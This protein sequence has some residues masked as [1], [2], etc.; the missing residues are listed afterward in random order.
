MT[1][2]STPPPGAAPRTR[3]PRRS[4]SR[5]FLLSLVL[6]LLVLELVVRLGGLVDVNAG[7]S[8]PQQAAFNAAG[9]FVATGDRDLPYMNRPDAATNVEGVLYRHDAQGRRIAEEDDAALTP[10][11]RVVVFLGDST[12]YGLGLRFQDT[13]PDLTA[14]LLNTM[15]PSRTIAARNHGVCG[16]GIEQELALYERLADALP[17]DA[18][19]VL[20]VF[21]NDF[22]GGRFL[23][24]DG[25]KL[26]YAD[27]LP[28]PFALK[29]WLW[30]SA[31]YRGL[32]SSATARRQAQGAFDASNPAN[33]GAAL[34]NVAALAARVQ[35]DGRRLLVA[36]LPAMERL[37][38]YLFSEPVGKLEQ[39][40]EDMGATFVDLLQ[41]FLDERERQVAEYEARTGETPGIGLRT[42]FLSQFWI[43]DPA[44]HH[45]NAT[46]NGLA[47]GALA[48]ALLP[49]L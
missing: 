24:D 31:L 38:P 45:L 26:M 1:L 2:P 17:P 18:V 3:R 48:E 9:M 39:I 42:G 33:H 12:T 11:A 41:P 35:N 16:Y 5:L 20:L 32:V 47:A 36:H 34:D 30:R 6:L 13:L 21:P 10:G 19:I 44:D 46:A 29:P 37:D 14:R 22:A 23:W 49:L 7:V 27:P 25:L 8:T 28:L 43:D 15:A 40:C 4:R